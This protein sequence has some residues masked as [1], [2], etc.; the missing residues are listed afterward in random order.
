MGDDIVDLAVLGRVGL[1]AAP[2]TRWPKCASR[3][4]RSGCPGGDG[5]VRELVE[6]ILRA[7][8]RWDSI[9]A[10]YETR[11]RG[12]SDY[13]LL[14][15]TLIALLVGLTVGKAWERYKLKDGKWIDRRRARQS[16]HYILGLNFLVSNQI[17]LAIEELARAASLDADALEVHMILGNLYREKGRSARRSRCTR[18]CCSGRTSARWNTRTC[19][20]ASASTTSAA[21]SSIARSKRSTKSCGSIRTTATRS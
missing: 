1:S 8:G 11:G 19:C 14:L 13:A 6:L 21:D 4:F 3:R 5:A 16:P 10:G 15:A 18:G 17:D 20:S 7:Q 12:V 9:V 2:A